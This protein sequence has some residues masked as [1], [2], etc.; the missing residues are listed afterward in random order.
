MSRTFV[1]KKNLGFLGV[2]AAP[3]GLLLT[4]T[5]AYA[6]VIT[7]SY[8]IT[9]TYSDST[10]SSG[11]G[12]V[13]TG[14]LGTSH[15]NT[16]TG[17]SGNF[18]FSLTAGGGYTTPVALATFTPDNVCQGPGCVGGVFGTETDPITIAFTFTSPSG[19]SATT[20]TATFKAKYAGSALSC[21]GGPSGQSDCI[22]WGTSP[23]VAHF[24]D[25]AVMDIALA[26]ASDWAITPT[27]SFSLVSGPDAVPE[28]GS[29]M[30]LGS[31]LFGLVGLAGVLKLGRRRDDNSML[32][33][34]P[35]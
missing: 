33:V 32:S 9:E 21:S 17:T 27:I 8:T 24:T 22:D 28:P 18:S 29:A 19:A 26:D 10:N 35:V 6:T 11:G 34:I 25:G 14:N 3:I 1:L 5:F 15:N 30:I 31:A 4:S 12:P 20:N 2:L 23:I 16:S 13:I 7:G